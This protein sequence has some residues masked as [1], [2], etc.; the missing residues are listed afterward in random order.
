MRTP[1]QIELN[2]LPVRGGGPDMLH[3]HDFKPSALERENCGGCA[4]LANDFA[5]IRFYDS[6]EGKR[7]GCLTQEEFVSWLLKNRDVA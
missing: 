2:Y 4:Q 5:W 3:T 1:S 6:M 7:E